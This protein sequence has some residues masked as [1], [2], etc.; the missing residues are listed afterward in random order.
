MTLRLPLVAAML[1]VAA[2]APTVTVTP[3]SCSTLIPTT[4]REGVAGADLPT[5]DT[6]GSWIVFGDSQTGKLD[7][8]N[9]RTRDTIEIISAC[10]KR[11]AEAVRR[12]T[13]GWLGRLFD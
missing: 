10:E 3:N 2:C 12:S 5:D 8:A 6:I 4:W 13:K 9:G 1:S 7:Q 11:D